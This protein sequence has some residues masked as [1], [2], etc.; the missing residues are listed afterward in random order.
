MIIPDALEDFDKAWIA[1]ALSQNDHIQPNQLLEATAS[2][3]GT[4]GQTAEIYVLDLVFEDGV[5]LPNRM[6]A[7]ATTQSA[8]LLEI[9]A[10]FG[11]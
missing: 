7:K 2:S 10:P 9:L 3:F 8:E 1:Q 4:P 6:L 5:D 11:L